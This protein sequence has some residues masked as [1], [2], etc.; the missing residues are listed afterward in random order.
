ME[1]EENSN[2]N[3]T[4]PQ[5]LST[6]FGS[7]E[8][9]FDVSNAATSSSSLED[10]EGNKGNVF[11]ENKNKEREIKEEVVDKDDKKLEFG[12][13]FGH[14]G[15]GI[16]DSSDEKIKPQKE[17]K[18]SSE[19][20]EK[21]RKKEEHNEKAF[22]GLGDDKIK[23]M[24]IRDSSKGFLEVEDHSSF[25]FPV[26]ISCLV[27]LMAMLVTGLFW[28]INKDSQTLLKEK[29]SEQES[30]VQQITT[31]TYKDVE[32][33]ASDFKSS[34]NALSAAKKERYSMEKFLQN[35]Y[36]KVTK[37]VQIS[38]LSVS[39]EG[40]LSISGTTATYRSV[41][42]LLMALGDWETLGEVELGSVALAESESGTLEA[43]FSINAIINK[44][45]VEQKLTYNTSNEVVDFEIGGMSEE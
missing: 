15:K 36:S 11:D 1:S 38:S 4:Q 19:E 35:F 5:N 14:K 37:D 31:S 9:S 27:A 2:G 20:R 17:L 18:E 44:E 42:D 32:K 25:N 12:F 45:K 8:G 40:S 34:V 23:A 3:Q 33:K 26:A 22:M 28:W 7:R 13:Q 30:I 29:Q 16:L 6:G 10:N 43:T 21:E 41:A 39:S 24:P